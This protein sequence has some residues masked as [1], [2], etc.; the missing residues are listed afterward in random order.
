MAIERKF[1]YRA[2]NNKAPT[3]DVEKRADPGRQVRYKETVKFL[4]TNGY[5]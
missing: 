5:P 1:R 2:I 4:R 3:V